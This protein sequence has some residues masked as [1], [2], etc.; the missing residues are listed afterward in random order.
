M[1]D[2]FES[3]KNDLQ[4]W[5]LESVAKAVGLSNHCLHLWVAGV[6]RSP[7]TSNLLRV[8]EVLGYKLSYKRGSKW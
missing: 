8:A 1:D 2:L 7:I 6:T 3:V 5:D 4:Y